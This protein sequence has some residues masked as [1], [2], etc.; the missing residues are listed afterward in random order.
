L[1]RHPPLSYLVP[2]L[3]LFRAPLVVIRNYTRAIWERVRVRLR[4]KNEERGPTGAHVSAAFDR[5]DV[6]LVARAMRQH[7]ASFRWQRGDV[8]MVDN[9]KMAHAGMPGF[10]P[11]LLRAMICNPVSIP[12]A[13][14]GAGEWRVPT[15]DV[16]QTVGERFSRP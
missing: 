1:W 12:Y 13:A 6:E 16:A 8:L 15:D 5:S 9:T 14:D 10:G 7:F 11:R 2:S 3:A 4:L